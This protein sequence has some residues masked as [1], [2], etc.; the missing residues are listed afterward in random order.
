MYPFLVILLRQFIIRSQV[1]P[2]TELFW[3]VGQVLLYVRLYVHWIGLHIEL[4]NR[5]KAGTWKNCEKKLPPLILPNRPSIWLFLTLASVLFSGPLS[6]YCI[7]YL[8]IIRWL[9]NWTNKLIIQTAIL[10]QWSRTASRMTSMNLW[11]HPTL[12]RLILTQTITQYLPAC[13]NSR[14]CPSSKTNSTYNT[15][16]CRTLTI[17]E[18]RPNIAHSSCLLRTNQRTS[19]VD[20][21]SWR[22]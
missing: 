18:C 4:P 16:L 14:N 7:F 10:L 12:Q 5:W 17:G 2:R 21:T 13:S 9:S 22:P 8:S 6:G 19:C 20:I 3:Q 1:I 11:I 15:D